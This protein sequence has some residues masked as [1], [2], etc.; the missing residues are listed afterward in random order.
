MFLKVI[1]KLTT[2]LDHSIAKNHP[3]LEQV[4]KLKCTHACPLDFRELRQTGQIFL[5]DNKVVRRLCHRFRRLLVNNPCRIGLSNQMH[6]HVKSDINHLEYPIYHKGDTCRVNRCQFPRCVGDSSLRKHW[7][8]SRRDLVVLDVCESVGSDLAAGTSDI[9]ASP[10][11]RLGVTRAST[12]NA[13]ASDFI[14]SR[15]R[16]GAFR[17]N[18]ARFPGKC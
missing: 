18:T 8:P 6:F 1:A 15:R 5:K 14:P 4:L 17:S 13:F 7:W 11:F 3:L 16:L 10:E 9:P 2:K 12:Q